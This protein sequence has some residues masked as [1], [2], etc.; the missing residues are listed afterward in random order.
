MTDGNLTFYIYDQD[1]TLL[2]T[3]KDYKNAPYWDFKVKATIDD[4]II[5]AK[6][7]GTSAGSGCAVILIGFKQSTAAKK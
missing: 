4:V 2:F 7:E 6:L 5:E 1:R 3:N